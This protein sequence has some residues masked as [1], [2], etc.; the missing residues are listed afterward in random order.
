MKNQ[1]FQLDDRLNEFS[2][3]DEVWGPLLFLRPERHE[4]L[5]LSRVG[6]LSM[7]LGGFYGMLGNVVLALLT[8]GT[9]QGRPSV[10]I[11][12]ILLTAMYFAC[13]QLS[14]V[15]AWN[16]RAR[17][18]ARRMRWTGDTRDRDQASE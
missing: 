5:N 7:L 1:T 6:L 10:W 13:A 15:G 4:I 16:R 14:I 12:P 17:L 8:H 11:M 2:D 9:S 18:L 3:Q